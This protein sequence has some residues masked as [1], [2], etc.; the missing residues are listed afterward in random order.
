MTDNLTK[1]RIVRW[2]RKRWLIVVI[3]LLAFWCW[4]QTT[5]IRLEELRR[6]GGIRLG[7]TMEEVLEILGAD[8]VVRDY[9]GRTLVIRAGRTQHVRFAAIMNLQN[10]TGWQ[11]PNFLW[12]DND[13][14]PIQIGFDEGER[15]NRI[16]RGSEIVER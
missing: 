6:A 9:R 8:S 3:T 5:R 11:A 16:K 2:R 14:W 1:P 7:Q 10:A 4:F 15:V 13:D 12:P